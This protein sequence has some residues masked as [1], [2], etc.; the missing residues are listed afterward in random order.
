MNEAD[1]KIAILAWIRDASP[2][3]S[4]PVI[5]LEFSLL[6]T[7]IRADLAAL[8]EDGFVGVEIKSAGDTLRRL[9]SQ[10]AG[11]ARCFDHSIVVAAPRHMRNLRP[12]DLCGASAWSLHEDGTRIRHVEGVA[13]DLKPADFLR[14]MTQEDRSREM[15]A[16]E[17]LTG[18]HGVEPL[19][20]DDARAAFER[21]FRRR[22][23]EP[24]SEFWA[25]VRDRRIG[26]DDLR[27]LSRFFP[28]RQRAQDQDRA[29]SDF[30]AD[31]NRR[32]GLELARA[33]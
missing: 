23:A 20:L 26:R 33:G 32:I 9:P 30:W 1:F 29:R 16:A 10:M 24:S 8:S 4:L 22:Y 6:G 12:L 27:L 17:R 5:A 28:D 14:L 13:H 21:A 3:D 2:V 18:R 19:P 25:A 15:R 31:W 11:Y 7:N